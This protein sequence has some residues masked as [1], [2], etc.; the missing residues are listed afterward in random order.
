MVSQRHKFGCAFLS[1]F[2][3]QSKI[4]LFFFFNFRVSNARPEKLF[5]FYWLQ[6]RI[7][8]ESD[9]IAQAEKRYCVS[10][11]GKSKITA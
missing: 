3:L 6:L 5:D 2:S 11:G 10:K 1:Y 8:C 4:S 9:W 7:M